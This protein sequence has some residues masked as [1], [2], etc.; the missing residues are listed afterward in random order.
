[1]NHQLWHWILGTAVACNATTYITTANAQITPDNTLGTENS[2]VNPLDAQTERIDG[3]ATRGVNLFHSFRDFNIEAGHAAYFS[4]PVGIENVFSR[5]TGTNPSYLFGTLGVLGDANLFFLNPNGILF[6]SDAKLDIAGSFIASTANGFIFA[7]GSQFRAT[8]PETAPLLTANTSAPVGIRWE[9]QSQGAIVNAGDLEVGRNLQLIGETVVSTG[10][11]SAPNGQIAITTLPSSPNSS[12]LSDLLARIND[13]ENLGLQVTDTGQVVLA[14]SDNAVEAGDIAM[15]GASNSNTLQAITATLAASNNLTLVESTLKT[16]GDLNLLAQDTVR[17]RDSETIPFLAQAGG[18]LHIQGNDNIDILA[19]NHSQTPFQSGRNLNLV[20]DGIVS[21]DAHFTSGGK[22]SVLNLSGEP[23]EFVS[24][25]DPIISS[26]SDVVLGNYTGVS[27]KIESMGS[28]TTGD[29]TITGPDTSLTLGTDPDIDILRS[30]PALILRAGVD[31]LRNPVTIYWNNFTEQAGSEWSNT[32]VSQTPNGNRSFLGEFSNEFVSLNI[33][34][35]PIHQE[36][37]IFFDLYILKTWDGNSTSNAFIGPDRWQ[38]D[39]N[40]KSPLVDTTF[41]NHDASFAQTSTQSYPAAYNPT[42]LINNVARTGANENQSL[43]YQYAFGSNL[44]SMDSVYRLNQSFP[45]SND[46]IQFNF[47]TP[48]QLE[49]IDNESWGITN[50]NI[51][52]SNQSNRDINTPVSSAFPGNRSAGFI[53]TGNLRTPGGPVIL[54]ATN[55]ITTQGVIETQG[56]NV[57]LSSGGNI[58]TTAGIINT[59]SNQNGGTITFNAVSDIFLGDMRSS[60]NSSG[61]AVTLNSNAGIY[62]DGNFIRSDTSGD[63]RGGDVSLNANLVRLTNGGRI[64]T[65]ATTNGEGGNLIVN[66]DVVELLGTS[67]DGDTSSALSTST[68]GAKPAGDLI[69]NTRRFVVRNGAGMAAGTTGSGDGGELIVN[70]SES[71][72]LSGTSATGFPSGLSTDTFNTGNAGNL[73]V[74]TRRLIAQNGAGLSA[75][76]YGLGEGGNLTVNASESIEFDGVGITGFASG[77]YAQAFGDGNAGNL[78]LNTSELAIRNGGKVTVA[79]GTAADSGVPNLPR[80]GLAF[81]IIA[82]FDP[83]ATGNA[84]NINVNAHSISLDN[85]GR[86]IAQTDSSEGGNITLN[87]RDYILL[88]RN[89]SISTTAGTAQAGGNGGNIIINAPFILAVRQENSDITANAFLGNGGRIFITAQG[90]YGLKFRP[91][92][93]LFSDITASSE[94]GVDGIVDIN[95]PIVDPTRGLEGLP[96]SAIA[97]DITLGCFA[98]GDLANTEYIETGRSGFKISPRNFWYGNT[99]TPDWISF[100]E[101]SSNDVAIASQENLLPVNCPMNNQEK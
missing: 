94:F 15:L 38:L 16:A 90:I 6:G 34:N 10:Q 36:L 72:E 5:V 41:S 32:T 77:A 45:H 70:A 64:I 11:L 60:G 23:G 13:I 33:N 21:G 71:V 78:N 75:S 82:S 40:G 14:G 27:L 50:I 46:R 86:I 88:R 51:T 83:D 97:S 79:A 99:T 58:N 24:L 54:S 74:N 43:G 68:G 29:I 48:R 20:S 80:F 39:I 18:N 17:I 25:Y 89:S 4:N 91:R 30:S 1:M 81:G 26:M 59:L 76:T 69:I 62:G 85:Q 47:S 84:G 95:A 7:D 9:G 35:L 42:N 57:S 28:I 8:N 19:L 2:I 73:T 22:F 100:N 53:T 56:G 67:A 92:L 87:V 52:A 3:G 101:V 66:A 12:S 96:E 65:G 61:G 49:G 98:G 55:N 44:R 93:T 37:N 31:E 63:G